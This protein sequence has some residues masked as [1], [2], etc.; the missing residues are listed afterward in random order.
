MK[1]LNQTELS[2]T[3][4]AGCGWFKRMAKRAQKGGDNDAAL[5]FGKLYNNCKL[6]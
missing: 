1:K 5:E 4:G 2:S 6:K 3:L